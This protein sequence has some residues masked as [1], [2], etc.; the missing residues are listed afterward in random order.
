MHAQACMYRP[1]ALT[2]QILRV[3]SRCSLTVGSFRF[4]YEYVYKVRQAT[5]QAKRM[6]YAYAIPH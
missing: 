1:F 6:L 2:S 3:S 5:G 4:D